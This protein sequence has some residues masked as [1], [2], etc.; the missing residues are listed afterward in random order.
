MSTILVNSL[1][2]AIR[3]QKLLGARGIYSTVKKVTNNPYLG[4]CGYGLE[5]QG[6]TRSALSILEGGG[7]RV[8]AVV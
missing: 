8:I 5:V 7:I 1:T 3:G 6:D 4:G 2:T